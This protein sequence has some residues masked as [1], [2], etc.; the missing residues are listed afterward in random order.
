MYKIEIA[1]FTAIILT[2]ATLTL[3]PAFAGEERG[4]GGS[5]TVTH[6]DDVTP[7]K[8]T[9]K[10]PGRVS[11]AVY[12]GQ[13]RRIR[14]LLR[15]D[16]RP[17]GTHTVWW[18]GL[19]RDGKPQSGTFEWRLASSQGLKSEYLLSIGTSFREN[20][21]PAQ[22]G[23]LC[24]VAAD[25]KRTYVTAGMSEGMPQSGAMTRDGRWQWVS[26]PTGGWMGGIDLAV[27]GEWL[28]FLGG[29]HC[30][31]AGLFVQNSAT[32]NMKQ[33]LKNTN[34]FGGWPVEKYGQPRRVDA[35]AGELVLASPST[36]LIVWLD[37]RKF[38][39]AAHRAFRLG[40]NAGQ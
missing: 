19:D 28:Y 32:G 26:G 4:S 10:T 37:H 27:D 24:A 39:P 38:G 23:P 16:D 13:G 22:H 30:R 6:L 15:A 5:A 25:D 1:R 11:L 40:R 29:P 33:G 2:V 21:W 7:I 34:L 20:H 14:E 36:G 18:D 31:D 12:D 3:A 9:L 8:F 35:R 17:A